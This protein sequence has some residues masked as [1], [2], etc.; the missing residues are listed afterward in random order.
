M[1]SLSSFKQFHAIATSV[2]ASVSSVNYIYF[3]K[4]FLPIK[5]MKVEQWTFY[6][7]IAQCMHKI[8]A[9]NP[10]LVTYIAQ[11]SQYCSDHTV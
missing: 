3:Y 9:D 2:F 7:S 5:T 8:K 11:L 6:A 10:H 4:A 1:Y